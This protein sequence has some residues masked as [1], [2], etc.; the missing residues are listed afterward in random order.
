MAEI[1]QPQSAHRPAKI[2]SKKFPT[3]IDMTPMVD[4]A[5][6]LLTFFI[7]TTTLNKLKVLQIVVPEK[8]K[9]PQ[10]Q[11]VN[12]NQVLTLVLDEN[13]KV[14]WRRGM[15]GA[16]EQVAYS[17][18]NKLLITKNAE[19]HRMALF[20]KATNRSLFQNFVDAIDEVAAAKIWPYYLADADPEDEMLIRRVTDE[21][22][23]LRQ[24]R[25]P[26]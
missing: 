13:G 5:F 25:E 8:P 26:H 1:T 10:T 3:H 16:F 23:K 2:R 11:A 22:E 19:I 24:A 20:I 12:A 18:L 21:S 9:T 14:Y 6:L 15:S 7:L 4:L 17:H